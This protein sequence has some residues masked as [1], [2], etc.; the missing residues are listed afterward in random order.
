MTDPG[1]VDQAAVHHHHH[2]EDPVEE[3][4]RD[5]AAHHHQELEVEVIRDARHQHENGTSNLVRMAG[6]LLST[7]GDKLLYIVLSQLWFIQLIPL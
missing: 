2:V 1:V 3:H 5:A 7:S 6:R 4:H